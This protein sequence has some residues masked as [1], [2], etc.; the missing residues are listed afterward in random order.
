M[1]SGTFSPKIRPEPELKKSSKTG[2]S[3]SLFRS[4]LYWILLLNTFIL[5]TFL[6]KKVFLLNTFKLQNFFHIRILNT[7]KKYWSTF[8]QYF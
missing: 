2:R 5:N 3:R 7:L 8:T 4:Q 1:N 6:N